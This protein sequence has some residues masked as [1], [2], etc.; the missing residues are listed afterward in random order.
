MSG[1]EAGALAASES[2]A[3]AWLEFALERARSASEQIRSATSAGKAARAKG[4]DPADWVTDVDVAVESDLEAALRARFPGHGLLG[5]EGGQ[6]PGEAGRPTW[7]VDPVDGTTNFV[8][9]LPLVAVSIAV[10]HEGALSAGVVADAFRDRYVTAR[11]GQGAWRDG[12]RLHQGDATDLTGGVV[13]TELVGYR[14]W[15]GIGCFVEAMSARRCSVRILGSTAMSV[16]SVAAGDALAVVLDRYQHLDT[17]AGALAAHEAGARL[18][19]PVGETLLPVE[20]LEGLDGLVV[21]A[22]G[23]ADEVVEIVLEARRAG[24][25][26]AQGSPA[27]GP[28]SAG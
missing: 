3:R 2:E 1:D 17:A 5:E 8:A 25:A 9:G 21:A 16:A 7:I 12:E 13:L 10:A 20:E 11:R 15:P 28:G 14:A 24:R 6:R 4:G 18:F 22:P 27:I 26:A 19:G 23:V